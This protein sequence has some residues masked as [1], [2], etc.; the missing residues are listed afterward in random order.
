[1]DEVGVFKSDKTLSNKTLV[2]SFLPSKNVKTYSYQIFKDGKPKNNLVNKANV[3]SDIVLNETGEYHI[4]LKATMNDDTVKDLYSE[5]YTLDLEKPVIEVSSDSLEIKKNINNEII[6]NVKVHDNLDGNITQNVT[7]NV[8]SLNLKVDKIQKLT[9]TSQDKAGNISTR[10]INI[11]IVQNNSYLYVLYALLILLIII[12]IALYNK[13]KKALNLEKRVEKFTVKSF[14]EKQTISER[15]IDSYRVVVKKISKGL[16]KSVLL[17]KYFKKLDKYTC[18]TD[19]Y[20]S[21]MEIFSGKIIVAFIFTLSA[22][23]IKL[24]RGHMID[25]YSIVLIFTISFFA[26]DLLLFTKYKIHRSKLENDFISAITIMNNAFK[27]GRS[28]SQAIDT[29]AEQLDGTVGREFARMSLELLYGLGIDVVFKRFSKRIDLE[30]ANYLTASLTILNKTGG[31]I[32][33]VFDSIEKSMFDRR[34]L[35]LELKSLTSGS[36]IVVGVL[37][38][39][40]FFFCLVIGIIN[41]EYFVPFFTTPIGIIL[42]IFMIIY[43]IIFLVVVRKVM[44][45]V[46]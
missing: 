27:S 3:K 15:F 33:K 19:V 21:G 45:V 14:K 23:I 5:K 42:L 30:E 22:F 12:S 18:I 24:F 1:M 20:D 38:L 4:H 46:V 41:P 44:K 43:Y 6:K 9:Y 16:D 37:L 34:K 39:M 11:R 40:P 13:V 17:K 28:I 32:I 8:S 31:D 26:L 35:R 10:Q 25:Y 2:V 36:K 7:T 29:V